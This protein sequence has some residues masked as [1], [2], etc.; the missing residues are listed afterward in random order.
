MVPPAKEGSNLRKGG[1]KQLAAEV[2]RELPGN[3]YVLCATL[4]G[5]VGWSNRKVVADGVLDCF[6][7]DGVLRACEE[8]VENLLGEV[9]RD[10]RFLEG[11]IRPES[12][13]GSLEFSDVGV[14]MSCKEGCNLVG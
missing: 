8:I 7:G 3:S 14:D 2:H 10:G 11:C 5:E 4:G 9:D 6:H 13:K 1:V 12:H